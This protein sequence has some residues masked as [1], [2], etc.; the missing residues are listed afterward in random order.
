MACSAYD[1][2]RHAV[3]DLR[4]IV[5]GFSFSHQGVIPNG[6]STGNTSLVVWALAREISH[7][8]VGHIIPLA[9]ILLIVILS[10]VNVPRANCVPI[11]SL[12]VGLFLSMS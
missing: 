1:H 10:C 8:L 4:R 7:N 9:F 2:T 12:P 5:S 3:F 11:L 6:C